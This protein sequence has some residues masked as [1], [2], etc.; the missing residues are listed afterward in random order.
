MA[1]SSTPEV[2]LPPKPLS[3]VNSALISLTVT[4]VALKYGV[5]NSELP[6]APQLTYDSCKHW[7]RVMEHS[8]EMSQNQV[9]EHYVRQLSMTNP[10]SP[11]FSPQMTVKEASEDIH[12]INPHG[13]EFRLAR[14]PDALAALRRTRKLRYRN[15]LKLLKMSFKM[16]HEPAW[17]PKRDEGP[18]AQSHN[19][20][21]AEWKAQKELA[22]KKKAE[23]TVE[24]MKYIAEMKSAKVK[25]AADQRLQL[26]KDRVAEQE[27]MKKQAGKKRV[28]IKPKPAANK[29][30]ATKPIANTSIAHKHTT[31]KIVAKQQEQQV[32]E[33]HV[34]E[35]IAEKPKAET[36]TTT[37]V[38]H[39]TPAWLKWL[40]DEEA[41]AKSKK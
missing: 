26:A 12:K 32:A 39:E 33:K 11:T 22:D 37:E 25:A 34:T 27:A 19:L 18:V 10:A 5:R 36:C 7:M 3:P 14:N 35:K 17:K 30:V 6:P 21:D 9:N 20:T 1:S 8:Y 40:N 16:A 15:N 13:I 31:N 4:N 29:P 24:E 2:Q 41:A 28:G 38:K 23:M